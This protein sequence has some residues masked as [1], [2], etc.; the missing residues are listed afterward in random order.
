[1]NKV[2]ARS[3]EYVDNN[4]TFSQSNTYRPAKLILGLSFLVAAILRLESSESVEHLLHF[5]LHRLE[6]VEP[7]HE[8]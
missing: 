7:G 8:K 5:D 4:N 6:L 2:L 1:M 3:N